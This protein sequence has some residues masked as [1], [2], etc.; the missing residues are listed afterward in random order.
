MP[1]FEGLDPA[2]LRE[3]FDLGIDLEVAAVELVRQP[4][5]DGALAAFVP[6][7]SGARH[8]EPREPRFANGSKRV[9][10]HLHDVGAVGAASPI[11]PEV[12][13]SRSARTGATVGYALR[14][15]A[16]RESLA[17]RSRRNRVAS[18]W[19]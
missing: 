5:H 19:R 9:R 3:L 10:D 8:P 14:R 2:T 1:W 13:C 11:A 18:R 17:S 4:R 15:C 12:D 6:Y 16:P 7:G